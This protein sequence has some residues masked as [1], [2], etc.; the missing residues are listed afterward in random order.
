VG[1]PSAIYKKHNGVMAAEERRQKR[2]EHYQG[3]GEA[4]N[5][6]GQNNYLFERL[7]F[8]TSVIEMDKDVPECSLF[9]QQSP[10]PG[11]RS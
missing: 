8:Y 10:V 2:N 11:L 6:P 1:F 3:G 9:S 5:N 4:E 7:H